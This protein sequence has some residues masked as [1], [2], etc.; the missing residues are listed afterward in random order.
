M[1]V[2]QADRMNGRQTLA[3]GSETIDFSLS[4]SPRRRLSVIV[5]PSGEV[6]V[7]APTQAPLESVFKHLR[8][9]AGWII[10]QRERFAAF[11]PTMPPKRFVNGETHRYLGR[12]YRLRIAEGPASCV[13]LIGRY[14]EVVT[15][16]QTSVLEMS[17]L[18]KI[19]GTLGNPRCFSLGWPVRHCGREGFR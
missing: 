4:F 19:G 6:L 10:R 11:G 13:K 14:F 5:E 7:K 3:F 1:T 2:S 16:P 8:R 18:A 15:S 17:C 12:Q 9:R